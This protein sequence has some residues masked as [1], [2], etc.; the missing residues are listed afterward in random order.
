[1]KKFSKKQRQKKLKEIIA[2]NPFLTDKDLAEKFDVS[3]QTIRLDRMELNIPEVRKRTK[4]MAQSVYERLK[5]VNE[6]EVIGELI[7]LELDK[8]AESYLATNKEMALQGSNIIRGHHI[9]AQANSLAVAVIDAELVLT[10][11]VNMKYISPVYIGDTIRAK[12]KVKEIKKN[13]YIIE[14]NTFKK[15]KKVFFGNFT[16]FPRN[17]RNER[18][19]DN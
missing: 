13:K 16:M 5:S 10:G 4:K 1:M 8:L 18:G 19:V 11:S 6:G 15:D 14:I 17:E 7:Q 3:I 12:A 9:F 2:E